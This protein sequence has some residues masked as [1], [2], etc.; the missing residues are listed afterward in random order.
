MYATFKSNFIYSTP[1]L[2]SFRWKIII[3]PAQLKRLSVEEV[4]RGAFT[5]KGENWFHDM[6]KNNCEHFRVFVCFKVGL[7]I[8][9]LYLTA[10]EV[11]YS[12]F[13]TGLYDFGR[14]IT[15]KK[16]LPLLIKLQANVSYELATFIYE[17]ALYASGMW[18]SNPHGSWPSRLWDVQISAL[19]KSTVCFL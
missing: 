8:E 11:A 9:R 19:Y 13:S 1:I 2:Y 16:V 17:N 15:T 5:R 10:W 14:N 3:W 12:A 7:Q 4:I 18:V 6:L